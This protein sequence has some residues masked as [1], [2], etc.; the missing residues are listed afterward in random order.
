MMTVQLDKAT[1]DR[2]SFDC[3]SESLNNFLKIMANQQASRDN[4]RTFVLTDPDSPE[5]L[6]GFYSL[7][8]TQIDMS[9]LPDQ[10]RRK[11]QASTA[12]GLITRLA[13]DTKYQGND[14]GEWLLVDAL[15]RLLIASNS[16][17]FPLVIVDAKEDATGF[18]EQYGF[19]SFHDLKNRLFLT[20]ADIRAS[21][22]EAVESSG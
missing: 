15:K 17:G 16:V 1:H 19:K 3:G 6:M 14:I 5:K 13:V 10:L 4:S 7:T 18:Y 11:H 8:M 2:G 20:I 22:G 12:A 9:V 21:I